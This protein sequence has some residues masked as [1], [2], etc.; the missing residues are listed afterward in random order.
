MG[1]TLLA[2]APDRSIAGTLVAYELKLTLVLNEV[3]SFELT[4]PKEAT[5]DGW[6]APGAGLIAI[7]D[8]QVVASGNIDAES[9]AWSADPTEE[10]TGPGQWTLTG[11]TDLARLAYRIVYPTP[12]RDWDEQTNA[13]YTWPAT[14]TA[15]AEEVMRVVVNQQAGSL[16]PDERRVPG[17]RLGPA[18]G[19][20]GSTRISER[21]TPLLDALRTVALAGGGLIFDVTD[22]LDGHME[23]TVRE[24]ADRSTTARFGVE[25]GNLTTL[26]V[27]RAAPVTTIALVA[28]IGSGADRELA[29]FGDPD[30]DP[31]WER[32]ET[33][34][35]QR[36]V[37]SDAAQDERYAE[38]A[39][40]AAE[41]LA[42]NGEKTS[43]AATITDTETV[44][45]GRD[46]Q[47]GDLVSILTPYGPVT[48]LV[49]QVDIEISPE[50]VE[51][52]TSVIGNP[53]PATSDPLADTARRLADRI[54]RLERAQ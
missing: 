11:D 52:I 45:W 53:D 43:V 51:D 17:L 19:A 41:H 26:T 8:S 36:Q 40:A 33:F 21:F 25:L 39:K 6:P 3:G 1:W 34:L 48:D 9:Y 24:P 23:F 5:P 28:G 31:A 22:T 27:Q 42:D 13:H 10:S 37:D 4:V 32:R 54:G 12:G 15:L 20:G 35:D 30:A 7:R 29:A 18:S 14:G 46:Y 49:R 50:G 47:L 2:R 44:Q 38:Y 16:A